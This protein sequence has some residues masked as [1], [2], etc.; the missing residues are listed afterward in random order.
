MNE[1]KYMTPDLVTQRL[2]VTLI[3]RGDSRRLIGT[4]EVRWRQGHRGLEGNSAHCV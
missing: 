1:D 2:L 3:S 4:R